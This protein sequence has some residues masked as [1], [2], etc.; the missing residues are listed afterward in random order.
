[1]GRITF[2]IGENMFELE[3]DDIEILKHFQTI[4]GIK[5][6]IKPLEY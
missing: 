3:K 5:A 4:T 6:K 2:E 1:M